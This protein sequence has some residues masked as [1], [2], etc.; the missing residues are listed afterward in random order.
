M[1]YTKEEWEKFEQEQF[2]LYAQK[3]KLPLEEEKPKKGGRF[4]LDEK[5]SDF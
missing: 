5:E 1:N 4:F 2:K 3:N